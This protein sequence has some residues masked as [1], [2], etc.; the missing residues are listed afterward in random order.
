[1]MRVG[2]DLQVRRRS[3][4]ADDPM[5]NAPAWP[6]IRPR[7][8]RSVFHGPP[9]G[10]LRRAT[11]RHPLVA[12]LIGPERSSCTHGEDGG[13]VGPRLSPET[14]APPLSRDLRRDSTQDRDARAR[15][16]GTA[17]D[18]ATRAERRGISPD[19]GGRPEPLTC[20]HRTLTNRS[21][22]TGCDWGSRG[23][24]FRSC[25]PDSG[26]ARQRRVTRRGW[27]ASRVSTEARPEGQ[28]RSPAERLVEP[29]GSLSLLGRTDVAVDVC[30]DRV[31]RVVQVLLDHLRVRAGREQEARRD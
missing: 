1:M 14:A 19:P 17:T 28:Q 13:D 18:T 30:R 7:R 29:V 16:R 4:A 12:Q 8:G 6:W 25:Q 5:T 3:T 9:G 22:P 31:G 2:I 23:G 10:S 15:G 20:A 24:R 11:R 27:P 26:T 21:G